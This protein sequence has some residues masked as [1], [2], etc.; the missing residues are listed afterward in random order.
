MLQK[1][2]LKNFKSFKDITT[3]DFTNSNYKLLKSENTYKGVLKGAMFVGANASGKTNAMKSIKL[4]LDLLFAQKEI[5][6]GQDKCVFCGDSEIYLDYHFM[7]K[8]QRIRY[9]LIFNHQDTV[10]K[11]KLYLNDEEMLIRLGDS[12]ESK[13]TEKRRYS[14]NDFDSKTLFLKTI[15]FNTKFNSFPVLQNW[16]EF[17][18][19]SVYFNAVHQ[20]IVDYE[21]NNNVYLIR[22]IE[23]NTEKEIN[24]FFKHFGFDQQI[25]FAK[26]KKLS[27]F[28]TVQVEES[29]EIFFKRNNMDVWLPF[30]YES[31]GN[32]TLLNML[33]ALLHAVSTPCMLLLDEFSSAFHNE[34]EELIIRYFMKKSRNSQMIF[35]SHSTNLLKT[36]LMRPDQV[37]TFSFKDTKGTQLFKVS[38]A[39]P[40]QSQN[41]EK[42]YLS[43]LFNGLPEY[44]QK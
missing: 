35:V 2:V 42:M 36:T 14:K 7:I 4:L 21:P 8:N 20:D 22:Y 39:Q 19:N 38:Q 34:L 15:Y 6:V 10:L 1:V 28:V 3:I 40:R 25:A 12:V 18:K 30:G 31:L 32:Q 17:L 9:E 13:L 11:E 27:Q 33:P 26:S 5:Y 37:F 44:K 23:S 24:E 43:G 29:Q 41:L 16:W